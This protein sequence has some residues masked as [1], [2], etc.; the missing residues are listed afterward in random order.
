MRRMVPYFV[1]SAVLVVLMSYD[2]LRGQQPTKQTD[3]TYIVAYDGCT[4]N[5]WTY[6]PVNVAANTKIASGSSGKYFWICAAAFPPQAGAVNVNLTEG[7]GTVCA[8]S[9]AGLLGGATAALGA[10]IVI[11]GGFMMPP[12]MRAWAKTATSGDDLCIYTS[13]SVN[14]VIAYVGPI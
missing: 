14:G 7:T 2:S 3:G 9:T 1:V 13:A 11:N 5:T 12:A 8:T 6:Y 4:G 10:N